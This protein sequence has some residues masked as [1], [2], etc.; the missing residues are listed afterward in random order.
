RNRSFRPTRR[1]RRSSKAVA[2]SCDSATFVLRL[3][4]LA[5]FRIGPMSEQQIRALLV[6]E[7]AAEP[8]AES[9]CS[10]PRRD[11]R[12]ADGVH[13]RA[14]VDEQREQRV[15]PAIP[16]TEERVLTAGGRSPGVR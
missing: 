1:R 14:F 4:G 11:A 6:V 7:D 15:P 8:I 13:V 12:L 5:E 16:G 9:G 3:T 10:E 2:T